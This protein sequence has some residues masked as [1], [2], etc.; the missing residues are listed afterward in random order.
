M[1]EI[2]RHFERLCYRALAERLIS[3]GKASELLQQPLANI[4]QAMRGPV[5]ADTGHRQ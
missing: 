3:P 1:H 4:E 5:A 2:P